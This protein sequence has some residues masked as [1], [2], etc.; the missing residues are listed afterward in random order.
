MNDRNRKAIQSKTV[1]AHGARTGVIEAIAHG[2]SLVLARPYL[3]IVPLLADLILWLGVQISVKPLTE[4]LS[5]LMR[6]E[7]GANGPEAAKEILLFGERMHLNDV[8]AVFV[9]SIFAG[10][11]KENAL[12]W[13][14]SFLAPPLVRGVDRDRIFANVGN[15]PFSIWSPPHWF[16]VLT[17]TGVL[18]LVASV[19][20]VLFQ[21]PI[22]RSVAGRSGSLRE[23]ALEIGWGWIRL[24]GLLALASV[25]LIFVFLPIL[26]VAALLLIFGVNIAVLV[27]FG[28]F[29]L[30]GMAAIYTYFV[31]DA[32]LVL[33]IGP[34]T[35][36]RASALI[37]RGRFG[38]CFRFALTCLLI[39]T[40]LL[41]VWR[42]LIENP[43]GL[44]IAL[45][46]NAFIGAGI[47]AATMIFFTDRLRYR[48]QSTGVQR[49]QPTT[50]PGTR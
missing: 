4:P 21:V 2:L 50:F 36:I 7:G 48:E 8:A 14:V 20:L 12:N 27:A 15:G 1:P 16:A 18:L 5:R 41:H 49:E 17:L 35:A 29:A 42:V 39:Q 25:A 13:L 26:I 40:G 9:P 32:M 11:S 31:F 24:I 28:L 34:L 44:V 46:G 3:L 45:I 47:V 33:R 22:A 37:V 30:G 19:I 23:I 10:L 43:P 38:E 6:D